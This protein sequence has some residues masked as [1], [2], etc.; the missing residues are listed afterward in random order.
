MANYS[1]K[2]RPKSSQPW[3]RPRTIQKT[4]TLPQNLHVSEIM[5]PC[6]LEEFAKSTEFPVMIQVRSGTYVTHNGKA[7]NSKN[8]MVYIT[9][10]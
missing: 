2:V 7:I 4:S 8:L 5:K 3:P 1:Q 9:F 6:N 10:K